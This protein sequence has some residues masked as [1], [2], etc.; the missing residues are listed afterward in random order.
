MTGAILGG[1]SVQQAAQFQMVIMLM[2]SASTAFASFIT[3]IITLVVIDSENRLRPDR[4]DV[5]EYLVW[6]TRN[7]LFSRALDGVKRIVQS[8]RGLKCEDGRNGTAETKTEG[9]LLG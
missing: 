8:C 6:R 4:A 2:I 5:R 7:W 3:T 1:S 9:L